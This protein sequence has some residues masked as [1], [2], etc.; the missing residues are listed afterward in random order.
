MLL[1][2]TVLCFLVLSLSVHGHRHG[3]SRQRYSSCTIR[4]ADDGN[5]PPSSQ[6]VCACGG[7]SG[8]V[9]TNERLLSNMFSSQNQSIPDPRGLS[10]LSAFWGQFIDHDIVLSPT[11]STSF[12]TI[13]MT[14]ANATL[15][16]AASAVNVDLNGCNQTF[17][18]LSPTVDGSGVYGDHSQRTEML[19][20]AGR[21]ELRSSSNGLLP[22]IRDGTFLCGDIRCGENSV[23]SALHGLFISEHN[24][25]CAK[26][27]A[28]YPLHSENMLFQRAR[29]LTRSVIQAITYNEWLPALFGD[30][31]HQLERNGTILKVAF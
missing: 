8:G 12:V 30:T 16:I 5:V 7:I 29:R 27:R 4:R 6:T 21:C 31:F 3:P 22:P 26:F 24:D 15:K 19:R 1:R 23:L 17:N 9:G 25:H 2:T 14:P 13:Q 18:E 28:K 11:L 20:E 10:A